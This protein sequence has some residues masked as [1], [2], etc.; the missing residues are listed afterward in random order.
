MDAEDAFDEA[1]LARIR[2]IVYAREA[3]GRLRFAC[4]LALNTR[5]TCEQ[6]IGAL[7]ATHT[8][9]LPKETLH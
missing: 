9:A 4:H 8:D 6:A 3:E 5:L 1:T 2:A 7:R